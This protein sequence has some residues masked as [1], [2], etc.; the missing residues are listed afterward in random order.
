MS[1]SDLISV[2]IVCGSGYFPGFDYDDCSEYVNEFEIKT[3]EEFKGS[4]CVCLCSFIHFVEEGDL[5]DLTDFQYESTCVR[6]PR[7]EYYSLTQ[8]SYKTKG[9]FCQ[10]M[11]KSTVENCRYHKK[12]TFEI[13]EKKNE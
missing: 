2:Y 5:P 7:S 12:E 9:G 11:D 13:D 6:I 3:Y 1:D 4:S 10:M 8:I